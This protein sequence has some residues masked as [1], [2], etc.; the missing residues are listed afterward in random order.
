MTSEFIWNKVT[1]Y[2]RQVHR[3]NFD[4]FEK[5][6]KKL[7]RNYKLKD[8][9]F[10]ND[11]LV[12]SDKFIN[13]PNLKMKNFLVFKFERKTPPQDT[14]EKVRQNIGVEQQERIRYAQDEQ[15]FSS[16]FDGSDKNDIKGFIHD[17][18]YTCY[19]YY[20]QQTL[21]AKSIMIK[22]EMTISSV[23]TW[24]EYKNLQVEYSVFSNSV[25]ESILEENNVV[26]HLMND[27]S[28]IRINQKTFQSQ[29]NLNILPSELLEKQEEIRDS[30]WNAV[31]NKINIHSLM[32]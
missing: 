3:I 23:I 4:M 29:L 15:L 5:T 16:Y 12:N 20:D 6:K 30:V 11:S 22:Y 28:I 10:S 24:M 27:D 19:P 8:L 14:P 1:Q 7:G 9:D 21:N 26:P 31:W 18:S 17:F 25:S 13:Q 32:V 2:F